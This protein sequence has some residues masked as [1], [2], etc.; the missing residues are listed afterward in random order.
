METEKKVIA[1]EKLEIEAKLYASEIDFKKEYPQ[2]S[3]KLEDYISS[4]IEK[5][6]FDGYHKASNIFFEKIVNIISELQK[7]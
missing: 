2:I 3:K 1:S 6:Y 7:Q 5:A 4:E